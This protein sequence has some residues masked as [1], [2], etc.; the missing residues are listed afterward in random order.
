MGSRKERLPVIVGLKLRT[1]RTQNTAR[2]PIRKVWLDSIPD[3]DP[4]FAIFGRKQQHHALVALLR[5]NAEMPEE[6][7]C[8]GLDVTT[9][10]TVDS[11]Q[12]ELNTERLLNAI[13]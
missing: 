2:K 11:H 3:F 10:E 1:Y 4:A 6:L 8:C 9:V 13:A 7:I 12:R 5:T